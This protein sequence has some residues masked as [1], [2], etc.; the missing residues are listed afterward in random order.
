MARHSASLTSVEAHHSQLVLL[1][2]GTSLGVVLQGVAL[3]P[4]LRRAASAC[5]GTGTSTTTRCA[6]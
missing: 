4:S 6:P 2:L 3:V 5:A 1:G